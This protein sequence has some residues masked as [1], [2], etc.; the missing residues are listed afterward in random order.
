MKR[1]LRIVLSVVAA[2]CVV[3][4]GAGQALAR[5]PN[6][7]VIMADDLGYADLGFQG[8]K[9]IPTPHL[10]SL[11]RGG[12]R[13]TDAHVTAS[14]CSP[15]RAGLMTGRYQQRFGH[16]ANVPPSDKGMDPAEMTLGEALKARGYATGFIGKWHLG[17]SESR[18]PTRQGFDVFV[19]LR[20]GHRSYWYA[21]KADD[22][23]GSHK[24]I[25]R[26]GKQVT[27]DGYVT[28]R[29]GDWAVEFIDAN[30]TRPFFLYVSFTAP[31][32][33][34]HAK[35]EDLARLG[36][37]KAYNAMVYSMDQ[38]V[39]KIVAALKGHGLADKT[40]IWFLSDNG[41]IA[42]DASNAPLTGKKGSAFEGGHRV[43]FT[44][45]W[46][47]VVKANTDEARMI[48]ALDIYPTCLAAAGGDPA[49]N[50]RPLDGVDLKP[51]LTGAKKG[52]IHERLFWQR[53]NIAALRHGP[54][55]LIYVDQAGYGLF[56]L[57]RT[58]AETNNLA[59]GNL[60]RAKTMA[61]QLT[62]WRSGMSEPNWHEGKRWNAARVQMHKKHYTSVPLGRAGK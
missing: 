17:A 9:T 26:N 24:A 29:F 43:P 8:S 48:S 21:P 13:F 33:P 19:G 10:D 35:K 60:P 61:A 59:S 62:Q 1:L 34:M 37:N 5:K 28:D 25:E 6:I 11:R 39:G 15:S 20:E 47:G 58:L 53:E 36:T 54:W 22:R 50:P 49:A 52:V 31:H 42:R 38:N 57:S 44:L 56:D 7:V 55:K 27:F 16:H 23:P 18:Y 12:V 3:A 30:R 40:M 41:G 46:P 14:V 4:I 32:G 45:T 2:M 51:F